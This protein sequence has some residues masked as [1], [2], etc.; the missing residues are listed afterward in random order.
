LL[1]RPT[2][3]PPSH[4]VVVLADPDFGSPPTASPPAT[5]ALPA[6]AERSAS[7]ELFFSTSRSDVANLPWPPLPGSRK[8]ALAI[9][10]LLP[11]AQ[12]L[13]G[14]NATKQALLN[15]S[16]PGLLH[17]ATHGFFL[18]DSPNPPSS[19]ALSH[20]GAVGDSGP[21]HRPPDPLLRSGLVLSGVHSPSAQPGSPSLQDSLVT[22]LEL[23]GL[24]LWGTQLVV[25][26]A[27]DTGNGDVKL[28]QGVHGLRRALVVAGAQTLVAGLW[29]VNDETTFQLMEAYYLHLLAGQGRTASLRLAMRELRLKQ[30]HPHFWAPFIAIGQDAPLQGL[31]PSAQAQPSP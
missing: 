25:L 11:H 7:L 18:E 31:L 15:L 6:L 17:I 29:K 12:L 20:F 28:G 24:D 19:R 13:L 2:D 14:S 27:C 4:S 5:Q 9:Q 8:E 21:L 16:T 1:P 3:I 23:A 22:A 26:S 10:R 30:S